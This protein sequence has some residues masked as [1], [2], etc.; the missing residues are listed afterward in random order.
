MLT[1]Y[2]MLAF[3]LRSLSTIRRA[4]PD[5]RKAL[6]NTILGAT[7]RAVE[8]ASAMVAV[9]ATTLTVSQIGSGACAL[10]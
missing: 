4:K 5:C 10:G 7:T 6:A 2:R 8:R 9:G 3:A 1:N